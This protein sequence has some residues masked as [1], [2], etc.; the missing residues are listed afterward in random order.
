M[1]CLHRFDTPFLAL[2]E[3][4]RVA[5]P[6]LDFHAVPDAHFAARLSQI[7]RDDAVS[8]SAAASDAAGEG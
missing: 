7:Y 4:Q 8:A 6:D 5:G 3:V 1:T 2:A